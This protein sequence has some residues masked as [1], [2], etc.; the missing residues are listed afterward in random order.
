[1]KKNETLIELLIGIIFLTVIAQSVCA[2]LIEETVY[3]VI[4]F[5]I[6]AAVAVFIAI[7][8]KQSLEKVL[9]LLPEDAE[10]YYGAEYVKRYFLVF[11]GVSV[12]TL[13][14][15]G[16]PFAVFI[17]IMTLKISVYLQPKM[18]KLFLKFT[19]YKNKKV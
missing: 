18:H 7:S 12:V 8:L 15:L 3:D 19:E 17:G 5:W 6:G 4:G 2:C 11:V 10:R 9:D 13:F 16:N 14:D 1:M